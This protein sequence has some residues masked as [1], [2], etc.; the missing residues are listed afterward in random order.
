MSGSKLFI[1]EKIKVGFQ[2]REGTYT[3]KLA[4]IIYY[5]NKGKLRKETSWQSWRDKKIEPLEFSNE[6]TEGFVLNKKAGGYSTGWNHRQSYIR[7]YDPRDFEFE[8]TPE[9]LLFILKECDCT[10]GKGLEGEFVYAWDG[11][12]LVLLP[13]NSQDYKESKKFSEIQQERVYVKDLILGATYIDNN[14]TEL[15]YLGKFD[16]Y[17]IATSKSWGN[18]D[19][20]TPYS[21]KFVFWGQKRGFDY[22]DNVSQISR[23]IDENPVENYD[24]LVDKYNNSIHGSEHV[25]LFI[26]NVDKFDDKFKDKQWFKEIDGKFYKFNTRNITRRKK[27]LVKNPNSYY[28]YSQYVDDY[29]TRKSS[30]QSYIELSGKGCIKKYSYDSMISMYEDGKGVMEG[31][32]DGS[33]GYRSNYG[34]NLRIWEDPKPN[35]LFLR[36]KNGNEFEVIL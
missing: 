18:K 36:T 17:K 13:T 24:E 26:K 10:K 15:V 35:K 4:Y 1:P 6:P 27:E 32:R 33:Y 29:T 3:G 31:D 30:T 2:N 11:K 25:E 12:D 16:H 9:N 22:R 5:D 21:K 19:E 8:I 23:C 7:V 28:G 14:A 20:R 34:E